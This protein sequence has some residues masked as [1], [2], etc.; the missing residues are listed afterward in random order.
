M[1]LAWSFEK[2]KWILI[3]LSGRFVHVSHINR[4]DGHIVMTVL[5]AGLKVESVVGTPE[6]AR[7]MDDL[8]LYLTCMRPYCR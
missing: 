3:V 1:G 4:N 8:V 7:G 2:A 6:K 5:I